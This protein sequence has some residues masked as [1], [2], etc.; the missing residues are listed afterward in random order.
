MPRMFMRIA[1][2][3]V[4]GLVP[5]VSG[6]ASAGWSP[7]AA[8]ADLGR[9]WRSART[10]AGGWRRGAPGSAAPEMSRWRARCASIVPRPPSRDCA[11]AGLLVYL[12][13]L[14]R[15]RCITGTSPGVAGQALPQ[16]CVAV[17]HHRELD[18]AGWIANAHEMLA[19]HGRQVVSAVCRVH[20]AVMLLSECQALGRHVRALSTRKGKVFGLPASR[21]P[22]EQA[23]LAEYVGRAGGIERA[24]V[25]MVD[26]VRADDEAFRGQ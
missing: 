7:R 20:T 11:S 10:A 1:A 23:A 26:S 15:R 22:E 19:I 25:F 17:H 13:R 5:G 2:A 3:P 8:A 4:R 12:T 18:H 14:I 21:G 9:A 24:E 6:R 16:T